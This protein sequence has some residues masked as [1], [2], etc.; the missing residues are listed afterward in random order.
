MTKSFVTDYLVKHYFSQTAQFNAK[1]WSY[2][3]DVELTSEFNTTTNAAESIN[4]RLKVLCGAGYLPF[5]TACQKIHNFKNY[6]LQE[7]QTKVRGDNLNSRRRR[8]KN[9]ED[10]IAVMV[11]EYSDQDFLDQNNVNLNAHWAC[12]L[13]TVN[14][15]H[16][17]S[18]PPGKPVDTV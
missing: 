8:T 3:S 11:R 10:A 6:Y 9:R 15:T 18:D 4:K 17:M 7:Y 12:K 14:N 5:K 1:Y 2:F 16:Q 13:G